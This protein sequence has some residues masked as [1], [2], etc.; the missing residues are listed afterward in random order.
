MEKIELDDTEQCQ[1]STHFKRNLLD[2]IISNA[3]G[4]LEKWSNANKITMSHTNEIPTIVQQFTSD[5]TLIL[6]HRKSTYFHV[7]L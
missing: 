2:Y 3:L 6:H 4:N 1:Q 5:N 7:Y